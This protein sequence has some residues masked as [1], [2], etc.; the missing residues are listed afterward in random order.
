MRHEGDEF[1]LRGEVREV[2]DGELLAADVGGEFVDLGV[3]EGEEFVE[4]VEL[5]E[6]F[7]GGGMDGVAAEVAKE[8]GV[9]FEDGDRDAG[10]GEEEA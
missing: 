2:G 8:V 6:E 5:V 3:G 4:E 7:E 9:L 10:A 1:C